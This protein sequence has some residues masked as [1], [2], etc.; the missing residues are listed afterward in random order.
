MP[1]GRASPRSILLLYE[2][3]ARELTGPAKKTSIVDEWL[4]RN[5]SPGL[6]EPLH[7][8]LLA[9]WSLT[10]RDQGPTVTPLVDIGTGRLSALARAVPKGLPAAT[11]S[12]KESP[13]RPTRRARHDDSADRLHNPGKFRSTPSL[14]AA[15]AGATT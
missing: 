6:E 14:R 8:P 10:S 9:G 15:L 1:E 4:G 2:L 13:G 11:P 3:Y 7:S 12:R 5:S